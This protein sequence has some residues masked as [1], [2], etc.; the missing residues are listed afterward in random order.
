MDYNPVISNV[1][2]Y[3]IASFNRQGAYLGASYSDKE[4]IVE[5]NAKVYA[6]SEIRG[7]GTT[8][9]RKFTQGQLNASFHV[10]NL[11][12]WKKKLTVN[13]GAC[14]QRT[15]RDGEISYQQVDL[16]STTLSAGIEGEIIKKLF[17]MGNIMMLQGKG[18]EQLSVR[19]DD[20]LII[21]FKPY[22]VDGMETNISGGLRFDFTETV[23]LAALYEWNKN[24]FVVNNPY[25]YNQFSIYYVMKF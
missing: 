13:L 23:F 5:T 9:L 24:N 25:Q 1:L 19:D 15:S 3:G 8:N 21:N 2:P 22:D 14:Y 17:L 16:S 6:L 18:N 4:K 20:G 12:N 11:T 7:Q 10:E